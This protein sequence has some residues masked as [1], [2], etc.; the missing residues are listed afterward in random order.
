MAK[1]AVDGE[2]SEMKE[3]SRDIDP[4]QPLQPD[5]TIHLG[6]GRIV[7]LRVRKTLPILAGNV[8]LQ[9]RWPFGPYGKSPRPMEPRFHKWFLKFWASFECGVHYDCFPQTA[10]CLL[11]SGPLRLML[12]IARFL[13]LVHPRHT[14]MFHST[15]PIRS[16]GYIRHKKGSQGRKRAD[17]HLLGP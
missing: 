4:E 6:L 13:S 15:L 10:T 3:R 12:S 5:S 7:S 1:I 14:A 8:R 2:S 11:C 17:L 16:P 9:G